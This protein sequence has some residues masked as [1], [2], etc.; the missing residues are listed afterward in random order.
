MVCGRRG[1]ADPNLQQV[2]Y[3]AATQ[4][5]Q[6]FPEAEYG[7]VAEAA[8]KGPPRHGELG[9]MDGASRAAG[10]GRPSRG[11]REG[12]PVRCARLPGKLVTVG[13]IFNTM[14]CTPALGSVPPQSYDHLEGFPQEGDGP[15]PGLPLS[16]SQQRHRPAFIRFSLVSFAHAL[17]TPAFL[18]GPPK[19]A[20]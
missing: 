9:D 1:G 4:G 8:G 15:P 2:D 6:P 3:W 14:R 17:H 10:E 11:G 12:I 20:G 7:K 13:L 18:F 16:R 19:T 5:K